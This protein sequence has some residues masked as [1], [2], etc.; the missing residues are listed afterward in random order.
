[1]VLN[2]DASGGDAMADTLKQHVGARFAHYKHPRRIEFL[3]ARPNTASAKIQRFKLR[4]PAVGR[5]RG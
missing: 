3:R 4:G 2:T 5:R 1:M